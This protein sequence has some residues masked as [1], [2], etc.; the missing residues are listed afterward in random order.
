MKYDVGLESRFF[1]MVQIPVC[2]KPLLIFFQL[3]IHMKTEINHKSP[4]YFI[5]LATSMDIR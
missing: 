3:G 1:Q 5:A 4:T 2:D